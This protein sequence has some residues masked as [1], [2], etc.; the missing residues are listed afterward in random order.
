MRDPASGDQPEGSDRPH[1]SARS[2][3][4]STGAERDGQS[5]EA[6]SSS[7][8][9]QLPA[10]FQ[11]LLAA[12]VVSGLGDGLR[13][14]ALPLLAANITD[15]PSMVAMVTVAGRLPWLLL[16]LLSGVLADRVDRRALMWAT[17]LFRA[18]LVGCFALLLATSH[19]S[20]GVVAVFAF[21]LG[22]GQVVFDTASPAFLPA[23]VTNRSQLGQANGR[24]IAAQGLTSLF[25]GPP[26]GGL[27]FAESA[28]W[29]FSFDAASFLWAAAMVM[30][31]GGMRGVTRVNHQV[32]GSV[33]SDLMVGLRWLSSHRVLRDQSLMNCAISLITGTF[34][35]IFV[36]YVKDELGLGGLGYGLLM[37]CFAV[38]NLLMAGLTPMLRS[39]WGGRVILTGSVVAIVV[40]LV[41]LGTIPRE[42][43]AG[44]AL[45]VFGCAGTAWFVISVTLRQEIV[46]DHLLARVTSGYRTVANVAN[47]VGALAGGVLAQSIGLLPTFLAGAATI[48]VATVT[49]HRGLSDS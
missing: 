21:V 5:S 43:A 4:R 37:A 23:V 39:R 38:G 45:F 15:E 24:L 30:T 49:F 29:L 16:G 7:A 14:A 40:S 42:V 34:L 20:I 3:P 10:A 12:S 25:I 22:C 9:K 17:D 11:K 48:V 35:A 47:P 36:L 6:D 8:G 41:T 27:L 31:I 2:R 26:V 1:D 28:V 18:S 44:L 46:P 13:Y 33:A 32:R 19:P